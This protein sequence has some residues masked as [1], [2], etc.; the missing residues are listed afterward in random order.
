M[1]GPQRR[2]SEGGGVTLRLSFLEEV[3][4][5]AVFSR[6]L[7][8]KLSFWRRSRMNSRL[9]GCQVGGCILEDVN[10]ESVNLER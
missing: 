8:W 3:K 9:G 6:M 4:S 7:T 5:E 2:W 1:I 10:L